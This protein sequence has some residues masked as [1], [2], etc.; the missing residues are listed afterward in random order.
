MKLSISKYFTLI[1]AVSM[2]FQFTSCVDDLD[3]EPIDKNVTQTFVQDKVFAKIYSS[4]TLTGQEGPAGDGDVAGIDEGFS[5]FFRLIWNLNELSTDEAI[6]SW[7]DTGI[8]E[9]NF[10]SWSD[11]NDF[12]KGLYGRF[13]FNITLTNHFLD[14][15]KDLT[16]EK[17]MRQ[18]A[19]ARFMRAMNY[20]YLL[21]LFGNVPFTEVVALDPPQQIKRKDLFTWVEKELKEAEAGMFE[22]QQG[23]YYRVDKAAA[24][25]LLSRLYLNGE[26][27][28]TVYDK[29]GVVL[30]AGNSYWNEAALY[31][32]KVINSPYKLTAVFKHLFMAD[33][34]GALDGSAI[35]KAPEEIIFPIACDGTKTT[36]WGNSLF[37]IASTFKAD[38]KPVGTSEAWSGNRARSSLVRK[39]FPSSINVTDMTD[40]TTGATQPAS[41]WTRDAR[42][43]FFAK[44]RTL[45]I[46]SPGRFIEGYSVAKFTNV[47]ADTTLKTSNTQYTDTDI[48]F[49]RAAEA[50]L[51]YAEAVLR[52]APA[53]GMTALDAINALRSRAGARLWTAVTLDQVLDERAREFFFEG[54]RRSDLIR[55][56]KFGGNNDYLWPFKGGEKAGKPFAHY[57]NLFAIPASD[58]NANPNLEQ[59]PGY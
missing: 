46:E 5:A 12:S 20:Y 28:T 25:L 42:A 57:Y 24:W 43:L 2:A 40:L 18:R 4:L 6:C 55:F 41:R 26:V 21:D 22:P 39:F 27:Y 47:R 33:N 8:P 52:G 15:T 23:P 9:L 32:K 16:D 59:N 49:M 29:D 31:A 30:E 34:A 53:D 37:L 13:Y 7:G 51:T 17:T 11:A 3:V 44:D 54:H 48:P 58:L 50:Y 56:G 19:E 35:N 10:N 38:M 45:E 1:L 36:S 14:Q